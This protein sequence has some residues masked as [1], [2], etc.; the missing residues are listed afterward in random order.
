V[1]AATLE[2]PWVVGWEGKVSMEPAQELSADR[3]PVDLE[4][5]VT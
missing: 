5:Q 1:P 2:K 4:M 3:H